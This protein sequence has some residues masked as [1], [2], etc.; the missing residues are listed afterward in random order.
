M[1]KSVT[2]RI[3]WIIVPE[4]VKQ[5]PPDLLQDE[6]KDDNAKIIITANAN[7]FDSLFN[8]FFSIKS[9]NMDTKTPPDIISAAPV[10]Q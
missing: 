10:N 4:L 9:F 3:C 2:G 6:R 7:G 8:K 1:S 5:S